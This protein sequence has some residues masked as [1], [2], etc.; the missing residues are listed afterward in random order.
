MGLWKFYGPSKEDKTMELNLQNKTALVSASSSGIGHAIA[1]RLAQE[2][3]EVVLNGRTEKSVAEGLEK[4][5]AQAPN[6]R[7]QTLVADIGTQTGAETATREVPEVD[8]LI[9]NL[10]IY[11]ASEFE[12]TSDED[13]SKILEVNVMSGIRL[14]RHYF[15]KMLAKNWGR[16]IFI[17]SESA[18]MIPQE[19]IHYGVT[20]SAQLAVAS[21]LAQKTRGT[22]VTVNSVL[23][24]PTQTDNVIDFMKGMVPES[25][26]TSPEEIGRAFIREH[27]QSSLLGRLIKPEEI[28]AVVA[29]VASPHAAAMNG[30]AV[31]TEGGLVQSIL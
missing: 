20:K 3:A 6:G 5:K 2:G 16:V 29:F 22:G 21:G 13:W 25:A 8:I 26:R 9:N 27:R 31:R 15:P 10:G 24:G 1:V 7:F 30:V 18:I 11:W 14:T 19:M 4:A 28:A 23:P 17:A 12:N